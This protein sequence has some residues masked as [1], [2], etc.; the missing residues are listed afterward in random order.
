MYQGFGHLSTGN[1]AEGDQAHTEIKKRAGSFQP[2][3]CRFTLRFKGPYVYGLY[4]L[5]ASAMTTLPVVVQQE[6]LT[7]LLPAS[8]L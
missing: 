4:H 5:M 2:A 1:L 6:S 8:M 3:L 7:W